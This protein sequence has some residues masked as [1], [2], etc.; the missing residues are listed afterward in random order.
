MYRKCG[1]YRKIK[2][3]SSARS[4]L[5]TC[6]RISTHWPLKSNEL[7][8]YVTD[9]DIQQRFKVS[10]K[11]QAGIAGIMELREAGVH[12]KRGRTQSNCEG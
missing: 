3:E 9:D 10:T 4:S 5:F 6:V 11:Q 12:K 8:N 2:I 7:L 1:A